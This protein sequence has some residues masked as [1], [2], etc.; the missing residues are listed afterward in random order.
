MRSYAKSG[1]NPPD[2]FM[3]PSGWKVLV[4]YYESLQTEEASQQPVL[5][6]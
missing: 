2:G 3:C 5:S 6:S 1:E 4:N